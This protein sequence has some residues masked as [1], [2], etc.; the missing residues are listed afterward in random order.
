VLGVD[1]IIAGDD[2]AVT[3]VRWRL[4][5]AERTLDIDRVVVYR[6]VESRIAEVWVHDWDQYAYDEFF[7]D[8]EG[9]AR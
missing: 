5:R 8:V 2:H 3:L 4:R 9:A 6:I 7:A 1:D